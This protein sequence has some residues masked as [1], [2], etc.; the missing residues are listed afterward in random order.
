[1]KIKCPVCG[2]TLYTNPFG[3]NRTLHCD[4]C[5]S[6]LYRNAAADRPL[7]RVFVTDFL[8][9]IGA[10]PMVWFMYRDLK[11]T[12]FVL[13]MLVSEWLFEMPQRTFYR[14]GIIRYEPKRLP[15]E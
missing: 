1:M 3:S 15:E 9:M 11:S 5:Q 12:L 14:N 10:V 2:E 7:R 13:L 8:L 6:D 4:H